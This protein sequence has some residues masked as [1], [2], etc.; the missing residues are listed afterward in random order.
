MRKEEFLQS[1]RRALN[2]DV[3]SRVIEENIRYYDNYITE[4]VRKGRTE[5][6]VI[7]EIG[8]PRLI[9]RTIEDTTDGAGKNQYEE[10]Y[11]YENSGRQSDYDRQSESFGA[12]GTFR[13]INL[14]K[15]YWKLLFVVI[16]FA[17]IYL[18]FAIIGGI[19]SLLAPLLGPILLIWMVVWIVK[20]FHRRQ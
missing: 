1:L 12:G 18:I 10:T 5:E 9:A 3:P 11:S 20:N 4:E 8:D 7:D 15:W 19:F 13:Y 6:A 2:G 14:N 17:I 16:V